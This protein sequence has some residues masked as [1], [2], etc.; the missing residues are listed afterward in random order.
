MVI[1][2]SLYVHSLHRAPQTDYS[3][4]SNQTIPA[5]SSPLRSIAIRLCT[6][7]TVW[8][9]AAPKLTRGGTL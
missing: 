3:V 4:V 2:I 9:D 7:S 5:H 1:T 6:L 8:S